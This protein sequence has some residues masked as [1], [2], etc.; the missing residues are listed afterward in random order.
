[1][2]ASRHHGVAGSSGGRLR[3]IGCCV[4][5][6]YRLWT[7]CHSVLLKGGGDRPFKIEKEKPTCAPQRGWVS[8][9]AAPLNFCG[10]IFL[11]PFQRSVFAPTMN[12]EWIAVPVASIKGPFG[13]AFLGSQDIL[14]NPN[15]VADFRIY[16]GHRITAS[17]KLRDS[18]TIADVNAVAPS[19]SKISCQFNGYRRLV[20]ALTGSRWLTLACSG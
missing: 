10:E 16:F 15:I 11:M 3:H 5:R 17:G 1:M 18:I 19:A 14:A 20:S 13:D 9:F 2:T 7:S 8:L 6:V 4:P 12:N